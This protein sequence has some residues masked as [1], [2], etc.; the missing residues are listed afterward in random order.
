MVEIKDSGSE[1]HISKPRLVALAFCVL[2]SPIY[3]LFS[4]YKHPTIGVCASLAAFALLTAAYLKRDRLASWVRSVRSRKEGRLLEG[5]A[6][7]P[8]V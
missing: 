3:L 1:L 5:S 7:K 4:G 2:V 6:T 8:P